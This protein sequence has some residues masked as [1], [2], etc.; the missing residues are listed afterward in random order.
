M[1]ATA[2]GFRG[3]R[4]LVKIAMRGTTFAL[5]SA[6]IALLVCSGSAFAK[7]LNTISVVVPDITCS[8]SSLAVNGTD[9][10][11]T[12]SYVVKY[13]VT[14][15]PASGPP[16]TVSGSVPVSPTDSA[17]DFSVNI[18]IA[19][20]PSG[21]STLSGTVELF[22][23]TTNSS[24]QGVIPINFSPTTVTCEFSPDGSF[25]FDLAPGS[26]AFGAGDN[27]L[28]LENPT[29]ANGDLCAMIYIFDASEE[30]G[31]CCGCPLTP[32]QLLSDSVETILGSGWE[33]GGGTPAQ[34]VIQVVSA[35]AN[36]TTGNV[37]NPAVAYTPTPQLDGWITH[38]QGLA[39]LKGITEVGEIASGSVDATE[40]AF[41]ISTCGDILSNGSG[42]G[43]CT[44]P[45]QPDG[46]LSSSL[47][48]SAG[49]NHRR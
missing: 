42:K 46:T 16:T 8:G 47:M 24:Y 11:L 2:P 14:Y 32:N 18:T 3:V 25:Y 39:G 27:A 20:P 49:A 38:T 10:T 19:P 6:A 37:C 17:G 44:C 15:T 41:L 26:E 28:R 35:T 23:T 48:P 31:E 4:A 29:A 22:D 13:S 9:L 36:G 12:D 33:I 1:T 30:L 7:P 34:G 45:T 5:W 43:S 40:A 21:T